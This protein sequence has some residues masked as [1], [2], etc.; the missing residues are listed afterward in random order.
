[1]ICGVDEAGRGPLIGNVVAGAVILDPR[2]P[3]QGLRDSK[4]LSAA[5]RE[6]FYQKITQQ[7]LAWGVGVATPEEIDKMNILQATLLAMQRAVKHMMEHFNIE[8]LMVLIDGNRAPDLPL[9]TRT[10]VQ[11]DATEPCISAASILAKVSRDREMTELHQQY[12]AYGF[13]QHRGYPTPQHLQALATL[14]LIPGY[15]LSFGPVK[16]HLL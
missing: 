9:P 14:G 5:Q 4:K 3:I 6:F 1:M 15:R 10:I 13:A 16:K 2:H 8:P 12:P 11:G 7:A